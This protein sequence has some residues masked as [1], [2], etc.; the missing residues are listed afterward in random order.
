MQR[1]SRKFGQNYI[2]ELKASL[3]EPGVTGSLF[4]LAGGLWTDISVGMAVGKD[5]G[6]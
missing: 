1:S 5:E 3:G 6:R 4:Y 2:T